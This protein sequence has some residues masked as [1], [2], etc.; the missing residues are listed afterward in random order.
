MGKKTMR[1]VVIFSFFVGMAACSLGEGLNQGADMMSMGG[2]DA[3]Q[4]D[5]EP[6]DMTPLDAA[7]AVDAMPPDSATSEP[8]TLENP[9]IIDIP[10]LPH[11]SIQPSVAMGADGEIAVA[12]CGSEEEDLGIWFSVLNPD[13]SVRVAPYQLETTS[14]GIQNEPDICPLPG[15]GYAIAWSMDAQEPGPEGQNLYLRYRVV[16]A[17]GQPI[18]ETDLQTNAPHPGNRWLA[19]IACDPAGGFVIVGAASEPNMTFGVFAQRFDA[20]GAPSGDALSLNLD[21][22]GSQIFPSIDIGPDGSTVVAWENQ[23][24]FGTDTII[25]QIVLRRFENTQFESGSDE[26]SIT[27]S[28]DEAA[29]PEVSIDPL[30]GEIMVGATIG[31]QRLGLYRVDP[32]ALGVTTISAPRGIHYYPAISPIGD[33]RFGMLFLS[34]FGG[35]VTVKTAILDNDGI[36][37]EVV[38]LATGALPPYPTTAHGRDGRLVIGW[39]ERTGANGYRIRL[40][41]F[42][43]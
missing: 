12:W 6:M 37:D 23:T 10:E 25:K 15:G 35:D 1:A 36:T 43:Q 39:T 19:E 2:N 3:G 32:E 21:A 4:V 26:V 14:M 22:D 8:L 16:G 11:L 41:L 31:Q 42:G 17:D 33:G 24:G 40:A 29:R 9:S 30:S 38:E 18:N 13:G 7:V 34:G 27:D 20:N 28:D 5:A